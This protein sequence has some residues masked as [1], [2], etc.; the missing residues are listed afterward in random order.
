MVKIERFISH[1]NDSIVHFNDI[2]NII[3]SSFM[4]I[5]SCHNFFVIPAWYIV[6]FTIAIVCAGNTKLT[7]THF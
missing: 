5:C 1:I 4:I 3:F 2:I 6:F 7:A